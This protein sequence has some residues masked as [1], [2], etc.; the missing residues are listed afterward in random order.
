VWQTEDINL[1][2]DRKLEA[3]RKKELGELSPTPF[4]LSLPNKAITLYYEPIKGLIN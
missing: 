4:F 1:M 3:E 2:A